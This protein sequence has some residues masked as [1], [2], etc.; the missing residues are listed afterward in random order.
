[1]LVILLVAG[2]GGDPNQELRQ[3]MDDQSKTMKGKVDTLP[4]VKPYVPFAYNAFDLPDP[5]KPR[6]IEPSRGSSKLAP[7]LNR[8][9]EPLEAYAIESLRM[10][11]TLERDKTMYAL[12]RANDKTVYQVRSGNYMGQ[13][14]GV[15]T[16]ITE[17]DIRLRELV[18][19]SSGDWAERQ[20]RLLLD[21][22]EQKK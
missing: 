18:Q 11:G 15:I 13:N 20:S 2:C 8:R 6:K 7:D 14:F 16:G 1:M 5:F 9:K 21:D 10:V 19:D 4:V 22:Q 17:G 12:V 3:W